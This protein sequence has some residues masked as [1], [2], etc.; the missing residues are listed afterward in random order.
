MALENSFVVELQD[1][2]GSFAD[3]RQRFN[4]GS[5]QSK[6][7]GPQI[8]SWVEESHKLAGYSRHRRNVAA[9]VAI[10]DGTGISEIHRF[11]CAG[12]F[13]AD[14]VVDLATEERVIFVDQAILAETPRSICDQP[15]QF[16]ADVATH[17]RRIDGPVP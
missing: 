8:D 1:P 5:I 6:M 11:R 15:P 7:L 14:Y 10:A 16:F 17:L 9:L 3:I 12:M 4:Q 2:S 13:Q